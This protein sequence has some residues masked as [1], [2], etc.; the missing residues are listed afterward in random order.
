M[1]EENSQVLQ[2]FIWCTSSLVKLLA[3]TTAQGKLKQETCYYV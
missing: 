2:A 1:Q 3:W